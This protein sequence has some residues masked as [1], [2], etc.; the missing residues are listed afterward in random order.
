MIV[1]I[2]SGLFY[3]TL[4]NIKPALRSKLKCIFLLAVV[5]SRLIEKYGMNTILEPFVESAIKLESVSYPS[6]VNLELMYYN[7]GKRS[8]ISN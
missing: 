6:T 4:G 7:A 8:T 3:F 5:E 1:L 2:V